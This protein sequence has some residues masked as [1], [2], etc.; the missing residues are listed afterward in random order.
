ME[1]TVSTEKP[2]ILCGTDF[3]AHATEAANLAAAIPNRLNV[4]LTLMDVA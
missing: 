1:T 4:A 2:H 3:S